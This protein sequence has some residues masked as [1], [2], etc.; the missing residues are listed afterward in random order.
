MIPPS[1]EAG[2]VCFEVSAIIHTFVI[3]FPIKNRPSAI[4]LRLIW[5]LSLPQQFFFLVAAAVLFLFEA[6]VLIFSNGILCV[7]STVHF[8]SGKLNPSIQPFELL[9]PVVT[10]KLELCLAENLD[11][12]I[13]ALD[14]ARKMCVELA[15]ARVSAG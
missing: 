6:I 13:G 9:R 4:Q 11:R 5:S 12:L 3:T 14:S 10:R 2:S 1:T 15:V 8:S 7:S